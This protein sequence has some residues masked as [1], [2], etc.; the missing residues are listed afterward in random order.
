MDLKKYYLIN[1]IKLKI[2]QSKVVKKLINFFQSNPLITYIFVYFLIAYSKS[3]LDDFVAPQ[4][5]AILSTTHYEDDKTVTILLNAHR[6]FDTLHPYVCISRNKTSTK[7]SYALT[8]H[9]FHPINVCKW[10]AFI[11]KCDVIDNMEKLELS[12]HSDIINNAVSLPIRKAYSKKG[13]VMSCFSP[14][15]YNER[16]QL[17][18]ATL[19]IFKELGVDKQIYYIQSMV[20]DVFQALDAYKKKGYVEIEPWSKINLGKEFELGYDVNH[21]LDWRNQASAHTDCFLKYKNAADFIMIG[22]IDD[23]LFPRMGRSYFEEFTYFSKIYPSA[24]G[25]IYDRYNTEVSANKNVENFRMDNLLSSSIVLNEW[26]DGKYVVNTSRIDTAWLHWPGRIKYGYHMQTI[27]NEKNVMLHFRRWKIKELINGTETLIEKMSK[28][29]SSL[30]NMQIYD[31]I[32]KRM[33]DKIERNWKKNYQSVPELR[34]LPKTM[35]YYTTIAKC[36][37]KIFYSI[38]KTPTHCPGPIRCD[39]PEIPGLKCMVA[40]SKHFKTHF[41]KNNIILHYLDGILLQK[42]EN[43]CTL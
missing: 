42:T 26:E 22:D 28:S 12:M 31:I 5:V 43:G 29:K 7:L 8:V 24:A 33:V 39:I 6:H 38:D 40:H 10:T 1:H 11:S 21:E 36:Y 9:A 37:N 34:Y 18:I 3:L 4:H 14:L 30:F 32:E 23:V 25:F 41:T 35:H 20:H 2:H 16:W 15:F 19:E 13:K 27:P 17:M